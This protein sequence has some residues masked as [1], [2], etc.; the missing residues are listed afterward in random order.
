MASE[1]FGHEKVAFTGAMRRR[2]G[3]RFELANGGTIF[4]DE[5]GHIPAAKQ[6]GCYVSCNDVSLSARGAGRRYQSTCALLL[7]RIATSKQLWMP[8]SFGWT[9]GTG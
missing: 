5:I 2:L 6:V 1:L 9:F 4:L 7:R 8:V 3:R